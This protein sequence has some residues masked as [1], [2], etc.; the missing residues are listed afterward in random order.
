MQEARRR[1]PA[2]LFG[3]A[4]STILFPH[5]DYVVDYSRVHGLLTTLSH[6]DHQNGARYVAIGAR[7]EPRA[8][9]NLTSPYLQSVAR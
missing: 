3:P 4:G 8:A 9:Q 5:S 6:W 7:L 2:L 1:T